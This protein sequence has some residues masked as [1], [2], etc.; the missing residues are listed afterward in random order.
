MY[1][2]WSGGQLNV[3]CHRVD[4]FNDTDEPGQGFLAGYSECQGRAARH[5]DLVDKQEQRCNVYWTSL[6]ETVVLALP[7]AR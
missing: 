6:L 4:N 5:A 1:A 3:H 2:E 7:Q